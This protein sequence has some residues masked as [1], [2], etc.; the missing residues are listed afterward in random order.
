MALERRERAIFYLL[1]SCEFRNY[2]LYLY[3]NIDI[4]KH[5][6]NLLTQIILKQIYSHISLILFGREK[7]FV[8]HI[9]NYIYSVFTSTQASC[10]N[11]VL[12]VQCN[13][14]FKQLNL[15]A[16]CFVD[17]WATRSLPLAGKY[18]LSREAYLG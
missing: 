9:T 6:V 3:L 1:M 15:Y 2:S 8:A 10:S 4:Y 17:K 7:L 11:F 18:R 12:C 14:F 5:I 13:F 16:I